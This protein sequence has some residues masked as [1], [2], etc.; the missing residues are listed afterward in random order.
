VA[1]YRW[2]KQANVR[3]IAF[4]F[5][6]GALLVS[7]PPAESA[8]N[9]GTSGGYNVC[10]N[11][12]DGVFSGDVVVTATLT[13]GTNRV[14]NVQFDW[15]P[16][17]VLSDF[18]PPY[19]FTWQTEKFLD[20][21]QTLTVRVI[22]DPGKVVGS[23]VGISATLSDGNTTT[24]PRNAEDWASLFEPRFTP[25]VNPVIAAVGDSGDGGAGSDAVAASVQAA[26]TS[27]LLYL[28][29]IYEYGTWPEWLNH[30]GISSWDDPAGV[31]ERWGAL[32]PITDPTIGNHEAHLPEVWRDYWHGRPFYRA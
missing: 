9:C 10:L 26:N 32:A 15:G 28:G 13:G 31:G 19:T 27:M 5:A 6:L 8:S 22:T 14:D 30:Y 24:V 23:P 4:A 18:T 16:N 11:V 17:R 21:T 25:G 2:G 12:P 7:V 1:I 29:D 20:G 3:L